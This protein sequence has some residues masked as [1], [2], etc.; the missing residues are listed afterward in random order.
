MFAASTPSSYPR[1][2][3]LVTASL[4]CLFLVA[5]CPQGDPNDNNDPNATGNVSG[6]VQ[7]SGTG[8]YYKLTTYTERPN[9]AAEAAAAGGYLAIVDS[10]AENAWLV[11]T[12]GDEP[13]TQR[14]FWL[15]LVYT[16]DTWLWPGDLSP[17]YTNWA[18]N[19]PVTGDDRS[20][21]LQTSDGTWTTLAPTA[22]KRVGVIERDASNPP[23]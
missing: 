17:A 19:Q 21:V 20:A 15:G 13:D 10:A 22:G 9:A 7:Y 14:G 23:G 12:F 1:T 5:G 2:I 6:W 8:N 16:E 3:Q 4:A 11:T 18:E